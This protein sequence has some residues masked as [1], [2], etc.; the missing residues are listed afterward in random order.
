MCRKCFPPKRVRY[1]EKEVKDLVEKDGEYTLLKRYK[2]AGRTKILVRHNH[3]YDGGTHEFVTE[4]E[5]FIVRGQGCPKCGRKKGHESHRK[6]T[7]EFKDEIFNLVN[8]EY[9]ILGE[10]SHSKEKIK[11]RHNKCGHEFEML[12]C[13]FFKGNRCPRCA[14]LQR[15]SSSEK[16]LFKYLKK[17]YKG[18]LI[19]NDRKILRNQQEIDIYFPELKI[20]I[21]FNGL[22]WHSEEGSGGK[23][24]NN[25]HLNKTMRCKEKGIRLIH[26]FEDEW[27]NNKKLIKKKIKHLLNLND[28]PSIYARN[29]Y[30]K[31]IS[32]ERKNKFL[33]KYHIQGKDNSSIKLGLFSDKEKKLLA[34]MTFCK[35][36]LS[37][38]HKKKSI[39][40]Y[41]L[42]RYATSYNYRVV[43][44]FGKLFS[45]FKNNY[46]WKNIITY[47]DR[48]WS[49]GNLYEKCGFEL[50][51]VSK[52]NYWYT[53][54]QGTREY[55]FKYR[56][57]NLEKLFPEIYDKTKTEREIMREAGYYRIWDCG[58][59]VYTY[60]R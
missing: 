25:Y 2:E 39:Y 15:R 32:V 29:C 16:E 58:N 47:A 5:R 49:D 42:S 12:C 57:Q 18:K 22:Y 44:G 45:Y 28:K 35:P 37:L 55:R 9:T 11:F 33:N 17:I 36:R 34:V 23:C 26:I 43:G 6:T 19:I 56:K 8:D 60:K 53:K 30:V 13:N 48:R 1:S 41:E 21:E 10:Y 3:C 51:H 38:G 31:E 50:D 46:E 7:V 27:L 59:L 52:P 24:N 14:V 40:D 54:C 20:A 4:Q